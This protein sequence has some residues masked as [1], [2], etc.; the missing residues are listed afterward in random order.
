MY[1]L[2][3][4]R[5]HKNM[6]NKDSIN[7]RCI[8]K[9]CSTSLTIKNVEIIFFINH[10]FE[11]TPLTAVDIEMHARFKGYHPKPTCPNSNPAVVRS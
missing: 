2:D 6:L 10:S 5:L 4:H 7:Y 3:M 11:H 8:V 1:Q 9:K